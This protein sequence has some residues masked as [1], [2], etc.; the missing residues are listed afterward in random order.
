MLF[1]EKV[2]RRRGGGGSLSHV[3]FSSFSAPSSPSLFL[4]GE[5]GSDKSGER[6]QGLCPPPSTD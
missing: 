6:S 2:G 3:C 4:P 1:L 5:G